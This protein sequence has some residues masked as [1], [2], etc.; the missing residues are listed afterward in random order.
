MFQGLS[1]DDKNIIIGAME[2]V[3]TT[4]KEFIIKEGE[5]GQMLYIISEGEFDCSK[6]IK[7]KET[8]LKTYKPGEYFGELALMYN[9]PRAA[10]IQSK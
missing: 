10:S 1:D 8:Y 6:V 2:E 7:G 9:A 5:T 3:K 4:S